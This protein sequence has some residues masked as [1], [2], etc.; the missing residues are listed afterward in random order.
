MAAGFIGT[1]FKKQSSPKS[2]NP[3]ERLGDIEDMAGVTL[4]LLS[5][6]GGYLSGSVL[7]TDGGR[8]SIVP[9]TY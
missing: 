8:L 6:A 2:F 4:F 5:R 7:L 3:V 9:A 1:E